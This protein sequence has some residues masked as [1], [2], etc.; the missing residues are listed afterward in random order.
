MGSGSVLLPLALPVQ[1][2]T[3]HLAHDATQCPST[4]D[5]DLGCELL[6]ALPKPP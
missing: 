1:D 2:L 5:P 4:T 6:S 3:S